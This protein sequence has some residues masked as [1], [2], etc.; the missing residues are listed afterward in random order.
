MKADVETKIME[1]LL[2][3]LKREGLSLYD[4]EVAVRPSNSVLRIFID[5][6]G[7]I[8]VSHCET[9]SHHLSTLLEVDDPFP[10]HYTLEV[11]SPGLT[12]KL[13]KEE[14]F[15]KSAGNYA[16]VAFKK[17]F[18]GPAEAQGD[19]ETLPDGRF[20]LSGGDGK[21]V[22]FNFNDVARAKLDIKP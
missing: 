1:I 15:R 10:G 3:L 5:R 22:E 14:H 11:S 19:L 21:A 17:G 4:M 8:N 12:R 18:K 2:P 7:G 13:T 16:K 9:V 20:R 6:P